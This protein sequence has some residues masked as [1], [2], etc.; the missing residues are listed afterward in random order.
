MNIEEVSNDNKVFVAKTTRNKVISKT[1][2]PPLINISAAHVLIGLPNAGKSNLLNSL[3]LDKNQY[4]QVFDEI[5]LICPPSSRDCFGEKS[6]L[7][8]VDPEKTYDDLTE[9]NLEEIYHKLVANKEAGD[10]AGKPRYGCLII[11]DCMSCL[12]NP[13][14]IYFMKKILANIRH[15]HTVCFLTSQLFM[16]IPK[17]IRNLVRVVYQFKIH[18]LKERER[19][20]NEIL[21]FFEKNEMEEFLRFIFDAP[22]N[23]F[24]VDRQYNTVCK[25]MNTLKIKTIHGEEY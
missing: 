11:D 22:F 17:P 12:K 5:Y 18:S 10:D 8:M 21:P 13:R 9:E 24:M 2:K 4:K 25:N 16:E 6:A 1:I 20:H 15:M 23:Y 19:V 14:V 3:L 7:K